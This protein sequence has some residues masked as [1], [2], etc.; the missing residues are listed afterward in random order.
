MDD[1]VRVHQIGFDDR[2]FFHLSSIIINVCLDKCA[3]LKLYLEDLL[4]PLYGQRAKEG[5]QLVDQMRSER[6]RVE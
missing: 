4:R 5:R 3:A 6:V 2:G 1:A